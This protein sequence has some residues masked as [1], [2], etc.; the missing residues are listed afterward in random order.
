VLVPNRVVESVQRN[1]FIFV[2]LSLTAIV[3]AFLFDPV[4]QD[5]AYHL[6]ADDRTLLA[7]ANF[8]NVASNIPFLIVGGIGLA[9][10]HN[11]TP[12]TITPALRPCYQIFFLGVFLT[13]FGSGY[14]HLDPGNGTLV[15]DRLPMTIA[16][17]GFFAAIIGEYIKVD[18]GR[19]ALVP[20]LLI[21][22]GSVVYWAVT[23]NSGHGDLR[24]YALVQFLPMLLIPL[25]LI[26]FGSDRMASRYVWLMIAAYALSKIFEAIDVPVYEIGHL[27]SGHSIKHVVAA[28]APLILLYGLMSDGPEQA[29]PRPTL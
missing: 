2:A 16:F 7:I 1:I 29:E 13:G 27:I 9:Y 12:P 21:G 18:F 17:M 23:E 28:V 24:P 3:V 8:W 19:K 14:Y 25:I 26:L 22:I 6:F 20:L 15:W 11:N 5:P 4:P 10:L